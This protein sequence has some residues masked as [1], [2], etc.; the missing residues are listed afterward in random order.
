MQ[1][2]LFAEETQLER[3]SKLGDS[4]ERLKVVDFEEFRPVLRESLRKERKSNAGRPPFDC[5]M[6]FKVLVL[7]RLFNLS[8]EQTE[9]QITDRMSFQRFL[10]LS[11]GERVPDARTI[12]LYKDTLNQTGT[13]EKLFFMFN[14][15]LEKQGII[16]HKGT[17]VDATFVD[18]P[19]Q[20]NG[21][22]YKQIK[23]GEMPEEWG[24]NPNII[25]HKDT[26][27]RWTKKANEMHY[28][29][30]DHVKVDADSKIITDY[31]TTAAN[32]H[33]SKVFTEF[34]DETDQTV[35]ADGAYAGQKIPEHIENRVCE[36]G[37]KNRPLT[38]EQKHQ[39]REKSKIRC[40][41]E[42]VF[43]FMTVSMHGLTIRTIGLKRA[44]FQ[45][46]LTNLVYNIC[47]YA[48][49]KKQPSYVG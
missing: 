39:N 42:H 29:Y 2:N 14:D 40:R 23:N 44:G 20:R 31:T 4:L 46:G 34:L 26:D 6:M 33:D 45:I 18:A 9:Y 19:R 3:L 32:V 16:T 1:I 11:L 17:I 21:R 12:W 30:K 38:D 8:D 37:Y 47:R 25:A 35:Y 22:E 13:M 27:A 41:I 36:K 43:G 49:L 48:I 15:M 10:G 5:V 7:Q 28:G 24:D